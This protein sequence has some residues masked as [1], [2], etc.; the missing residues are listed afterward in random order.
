MELRVEILSDRVVEHLA[1]N[2]VYLDEFAPM[3]RERP[4]DVD[5]VELE[6]LGEAIAE[7]MQ[8]NAPVT[9]DGVPVIARI[10]GLRLSAVDPS[11]LPLFPRSGMRGMRRVEFEAVYPVKQ[12]P[13]LVTIGWNI[14]PEDLLSKPDQV[15]YIVIAGE[16]EG[17][18]RRQGMELSRDTPQ[19]EWRAP[20]GAPAD[21]LLAVPA[22]PTLVGE[23]DWKSAS[24]V[25]WIMAAACG[26]LGLFNWLHKSARGSARTLVTVTLGVLALGGAG[27]A[28]ALTR[29][30]PTLPLPSHAQV[31]AA[32]TPLHANLYRALDYVREGDV[33]DVLSRSAHGS[34]LEDLYRQMRKALT[35]EEAGGA[36]GRVLA[37]RPLETTVEK[38]EAVPVAQPAAPRSHLGREGFRVEFV[39]VTRWQVE[40]TVSH[41]GH[42]HNRTNEY[43]ARY[44]V[45]ATPE[46]WRIISEELLDEKRVDVPP[47]EQ[48]PDGDEVL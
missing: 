18:G 31:L 34:M 4:D 16:L 19:V 7:A 30:A 14:Y 24:L 23:T 42:R 10:D 39:V 25:A 40:G 6:H 13:R 12:P 38:I 11:L 28:I 43:R 48:P 9:V 5:P 21:E 29:M 1:M 47:E 8:K 20:I 3:A 17:E 22:P 36:V 15:R 2:L 27:V 41:W 33:Y 37:V 26:V 44:R 35:I 46:G 32:F 45:A